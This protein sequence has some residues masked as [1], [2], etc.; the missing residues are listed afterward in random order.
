MMNNTKPVGET[1]KPLLQIIENAIWEYELV[2][3]LTPEFDDESF[4]SIIKI[5]AAALIERVWRLQE[6]EN[7]S[8]NDRVNMALS[9]AEELRKFIKVYTNI[10]TTSFYQDTINPPTEDE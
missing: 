2:S 10:D 8:D 9:A 1:V 7:M 6:N 5:F 4:R 3:P